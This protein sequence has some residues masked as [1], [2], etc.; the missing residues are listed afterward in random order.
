MALP[1]INQPLFSLTIPSTKAKIKYRPFTVKEEKILLIAQE[2]GD[3]DQTVLAIK[4]IIN[5]CIE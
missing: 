2:S 4:Q 5:N 1:K 3:S